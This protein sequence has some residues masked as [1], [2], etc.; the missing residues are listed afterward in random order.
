[1][2]SITKKVHQMNNKERFQNFQGLKNKAFY[3]TQAI[4]NNQ[5]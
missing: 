1:M 3:L 2:S 4:V 5:F